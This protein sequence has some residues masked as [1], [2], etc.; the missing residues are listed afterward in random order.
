[1]QDYA[2]LFIE[3]YG[4]G[5]LASNDLPDNAKVTICDHDDYYYVYECESD[6]FAEKIANWFLSCEDRQSNCYFFQLIKNH[7]RYFHTEIIE[8]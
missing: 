4:H 6:E 5:K 7:P 1:M 2:Y 3:K 8:G